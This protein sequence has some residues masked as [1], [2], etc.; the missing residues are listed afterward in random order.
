MTRAI[1][2]PVPGTG[3]STNICAAA[4]IGAG[5]T[6]PPPTSLGAPASRPAGLPAGR[7]RAR[8]PA[9]SIRDLREPLETTSRNLAETRLTEWVSLSG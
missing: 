4:A 5:G 9:R 1:D 7:A 8:Y 6:S 2:G 3:P